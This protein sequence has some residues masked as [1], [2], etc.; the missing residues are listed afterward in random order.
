MLIQVISDFWEDVP[1]I[2][3]RV[4]PTNPGWKSDGSNVMGR[5]LASECVRRYPGI[6]KW[7]GYRLRT[8]YKTTPAA[9]EMPMKHRDH[10]LIFCPVKKFIA[11]SPHLCWQA[12]ADIKLVNYNLYQLAVYYNRYADSEGHRDGMIG[13]PLLGCGNGRLSPADVLPLMMDHL[14]DTFTLLVRQDEFNVAMGG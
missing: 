11:A 8:Q 4:I 13:I 14:S 7:Y 9:I 1:G 2:V 3:L 5:G 10:P 6:A 12:D